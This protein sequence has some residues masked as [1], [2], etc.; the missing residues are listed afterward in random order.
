MVKP[1]CTCGDN[2]EIL[3]PG[4]ADYCG[5]HLPNCHWRL[6]IQGQE[7]LI[8]ISNAFKSPQGL[9][10]LDPVS[11]NTWEPYYDTMEPKTP[12]DD[13]KATS[14]PMLFKAVLETPPS[15]TYNESELVPN[16]SDKPLIY[17]RP[18]MFRFWL[19]YI[20]RKFYD[21]QRVS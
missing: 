20:Q 15:L 13:T 6:Y 17:K 10:V 2:I 16:P 18:T 7:D 12:K 21:L 8:A 11:V 14:L 9:N 4:E 3:F 1:T 5:R 19:R